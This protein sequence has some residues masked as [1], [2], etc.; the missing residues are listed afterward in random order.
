MTRTAYA[1]LTAM[2][3][4]LVFALS[5]QGA[6]ALD[7][8]AESVENYSGCGCDSGDLDYCN[9]QAGMFIDKIDNWHTRKFYYKNSSAW[10]GDLVED[11]LGTGG[12]DYPYGDTVQILF[13]C[14]HGGSNQ[15]TYDGYLCKH[16]GYTPCSYSTSNVYLGETADQP[17]SAHPGTLRFLILSTCDSVNKNKAFDVWMPVFWRGKNLMYVMGYHGDSADGETTDEV[18]EDFARKAAGSGWKLKKAWFWAIEDWWVDDTGALI[19]RGASR[20]EAI[21]NRDA[22]KLDW[23]PPSTSLWPPTWGAWAWHEG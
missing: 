16:S 13:V 20:P 10:N 5:P 15:T 12:T 6:R 8:G 23:P 14:G 4:V 19:S 17:N 9:D 22:M 21:G 2:L 1:A 7:A 11:Q 18:G 3:V